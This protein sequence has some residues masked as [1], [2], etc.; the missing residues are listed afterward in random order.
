MEKKK[1]NYSIE[2]TKKMF[3]DVK[4]NC[5]LFSKEFEI[6]CEGIRCVDPKTLDKVKEDVYFVIL[7][8]RKK[9][10]P[11]CWLHKDDLKNKKGI[12]FIA[13]SFFKDQKTRDNMRKSH[14]PKGEFN[15]LNHYLEI[16]HEIA[17]YH[18]GHIGSSNKNIY[19]KQEDEAKAQAENWLGDCEWSDE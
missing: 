7:S 15:R 6:F 5:H 9:G 3:K 12:I 1:K 2:E 18:K 16:L 19:D 8:S 13:P 10:G 11:A 17:H 4:K 14:F